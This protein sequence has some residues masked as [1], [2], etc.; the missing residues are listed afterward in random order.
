MSDVQLDTCPIN[1]KSMLVV[2]RNI[3]SIIN[4]FF[5]LEDLKSIGIRWNLCLPP[6]QQS[7]IRLICLTLSEF[8]ISYPG[9]AMLC[10]ML[11][12]IYA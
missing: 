3:K 11:C 6:P 8:F 9:M 1:G 5:V 7:K 12:P 4:L 2:L 10:S